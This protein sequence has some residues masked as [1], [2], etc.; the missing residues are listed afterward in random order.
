V[1]GYRVYRNN[2]TTPLATL[3]ATTTTYTDTTAAA[4]TAYTYQVDAIDAAGNASA[5]ANVSITTPT[6][7]TTLTFAPTDDAYVDASNPTVNYGT[8]NRLGVDGSPV[9]RSLLKFNV[10]G[11]AASCT[12]TSA[13]LRLTVGSTTNDNSPY[14]GDFYGVPDTTWTEGTV[15]W[16]NQPTAS[17]TKVASIATSVALNTTYTVNV[18]PLVTGYGVVSIEITSPNADGARYWSKDGATAAQAPQ[19]QVTCA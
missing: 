7:G 2:S 4:G 3:G 5:K 10:T 13:K 11:T 1:T 14:G 19:L 12:V 8:S 6:S 9:T 16:N 17:T 15:T 18:T